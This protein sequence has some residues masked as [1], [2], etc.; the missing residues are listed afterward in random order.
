MMSLPKEQCIQEA[1][2]VGAGR[3]V[4]EIST[5][6]QYKRKIVPY[7]TQLKRGHPEAARKE[8]ISQ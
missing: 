5:H 2:A 6:T 7:P 8:G 4:E 3:E 1:W